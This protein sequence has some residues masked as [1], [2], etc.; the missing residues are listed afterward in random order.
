M[1]CGFRA[2]FDAAAHP[3]AT[4]FPGGFNPD[5]PA[6]IIWSIVIGKPPVNVTGR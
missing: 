4:R 5:I 2:L 3:V 6:A 1:P